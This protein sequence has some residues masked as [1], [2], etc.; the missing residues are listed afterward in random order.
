[1]YS[2]W[3]EE[4][5]FAVTKRRTTLESWK[6]QWQGDLPCERYPYAE[7]THPFQQLEQLFVCLEHKP[8]WGQSLC[9]QRLSHYLV[10][11]IGLPCE[12]AGVCPTWRVTDSVSWA[13]CKGISMQDVCQSVSWHSGNTFARSY[14][15]DITSIPLACSVLCAATSSDPELFR[16]PHPAL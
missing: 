1:M 15:L 10:K 14:S 7:C 12:A 4:H 16:T 11:A 3:Q 13:V 2:F 8:E 5:V 9:Q 6:W